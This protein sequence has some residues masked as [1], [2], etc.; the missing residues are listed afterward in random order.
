MVI[1]FL[2]LEADL[3]EIPIAKSSLKPDEE[4][5]LLR[6]QVEVSKFTSTD[7]IDVYNICMVYF[8]MF[9]ENAYFLIKQCDSS[10]LY[11]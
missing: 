4:L 3:V 5:R 9:S 10:L 7:F 6:R 2:V 11:F 8:K 1:I